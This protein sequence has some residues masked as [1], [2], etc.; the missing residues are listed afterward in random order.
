VALYAMGGGHGHVMRA[1]AIARALPPHVERLLLVPERLQS[2]VS[3][4][5]PCAS[6]PSTEREPLAAWCADVLAEMKP[7]VL[8]VDVFP[9]GVL[10][11]LWPALPHLAPHRLLVTRRVDARYYAAAGVHEALPHYDR[12][13]CTEAQSFGQ[14]HE[15]RVPPVVLCER[16]D[17]LEPEAAREALGLTGP[18]APLMGIG[19]GDAG[20]EADLETALAACGRPYVMFGWTRGRHEFPAARYFRGAACAVSAAGYQS[21]WELMHAGTPAV[22]LAQQRKLDDQLWRAGALA[23]EQCVVVDSFEAVPAAVDRLLSGPTAPPPAQ[24]ASVSL[25]P[26]SGARA[27]AAAIAEC[28]A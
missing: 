9:R 5:Q 18:V 27:V 10:G 17:M 6:P 19:N 1:L 26:G 23:S 21:G 28:M 25:C 13:L 11:E 8:V 12:I 20:F 7:Q 3:R 15:Q 14:R 2:T 22:L 4:Y 24:P 16:E